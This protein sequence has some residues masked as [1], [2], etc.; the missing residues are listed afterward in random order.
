[1]KSQDNIKKFEYIDILRGIA[2]LGVIAV[3]SYPGI[4][5]LSLLTCYIF[6]YGQLGVQLFFFAS[7]LTLCLSISERNENSITNFYARRFFRIAPLYYFGIFLYFMQKFLT[8]YYINGGTSVPPGYTIT[9]I[10]LNIFFVHG[11]HPVYFNQLVPGGWSI[12][13]EMAFYCIFPFLYI[14]LST[15]K[16]R[17]FII[18]SL[19]I[20]ICSFL[21][22]LIYIYNIEPILVEKHILN[23]VVLNDGFGFIYA[24]ILNQINVF[25]IGM[26]TF[27][28][29]KKNITHVQISF[30]VLLMI[31]SCFILNTSTYK[32]GVNGFFFPILSTVSFGIIAVKLSNVDKFNTKISRILI[33][34]GQFSFSM[35]ILHF[36]ILDLLH[37][38][39]DNTL[40]KAIDIAEVKLLITFLSLLFFTYLASNITNRFV[41]KPGIKLGKRFI[42]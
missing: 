39:L 32:T 4:D 13:T 19:T 23:R 27:K 40:F 24:L 38:I 17:I 37:F 8:A 18:F 25:L 31:V 21:I 29:L 20:S 1:M 36:I 22:Q 15:F 28:L 9:S 6:Q 26:I 3:H 10:L 30:A 33:R 7:A 12:A 42:K 2:I 35:Y 16:L 11:F 34:I 14:L 5:N 41:E